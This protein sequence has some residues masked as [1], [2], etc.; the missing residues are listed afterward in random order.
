MKRFSL[1]KFWGDQRGNILIFTGLGVL[2]L[3][4]IGGAG[5]DL[6]RQQLVRQ[7]IQQASDAAALAAAGMDFG[8][9]DA[10]RQN[11][12]NAFFSLNYPNNYL[13]IARPTPS[14]SIA[15]ETIT[16]SA[17]TAVPTSFVGNF[18][19]SSITAAGTS[20]TQFKRLQTV[21]DAI[22]VLDNSGSMGHNPLSYDVG[23]GNSMDASGVVRPVCRAGWIAYSAFFGPPM[24]NA[25]ANFY[26][27]LYE[28]A[29]GFNRI[30]ALRFSA[31]ALTDTLMNPNPNN[32]RIALA[33]WDSF[34]I[35]S[36]NFS[37][38]AAT[39]KSF[40]SMMYGRGA[41][42]STM[43]MQQAQTLAVKFRPN[44]ARAVILM[45]DGFNNLGSR[46]PDGTLKTPAQIAVDQA[47]INAASLAICNAFK[48]QGTI[49]YT[50]GFGSELVGTNPLIVAADQFLSDCATGP[51]GVAKPNLN[52]F[53]FRAPDAAALAA[54][55]NA[56]SGSLKK[57]Q[58]LQ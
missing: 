29:N 18:G 3:V 32:N 17:N 15:G 26:C 10:T 28:G 40:L 8:T 6:G 20:R 51:N 5:Y 11:T 14:I 34:A 43:G 19:V 53:Y 30:N 22:L 42:N 27:N 36:Q 9:S 55:F 13:G 38:N 45:T 54:A 7:K 48:A 21:I 31:S 41:T 50:I 4:G 35:S 49:V 2:F 23:T 39:V 1:Q 16:V 24:N 12:A 52:T 33:T 37:I 57:V 25:D 56:I 58:I 44:V 46:N 47:G